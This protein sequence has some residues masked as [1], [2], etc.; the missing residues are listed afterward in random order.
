MTTKPKPQ[1][2]N[3]SD[4]MFMMS[5]CAGQWADY[6]MDKYGLTLEE[7]DRSIYLTM[8]DYDLEESEDA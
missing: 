1:P 3:M 2:G 5:N 6:I 8:F 4:F 7:Y